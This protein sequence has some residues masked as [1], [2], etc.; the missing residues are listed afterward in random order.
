MIELQNAVGINDHNRIV[1]KMKSDMLKLI[2]SGT[3]K[4]YNDKASEILKSIG[5]VFKGFIC[6]KFMNEKYYV[7][8][9]KD[10]MVFYLIPKLIKGVKLKPMIK[11]SRENIILGREK[12]TKTMNKLITIFV[13]ENQ[14]SVCIIQT[15]NQDKREMFIT[16]SNDKIVCDVSTITNEYQKDIIEV[17]NCSS[18]I[19]YTLLKNVLY[20]IIK[21][22]EKYD[23]ST[24]KKRSD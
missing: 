23:K 22:R 7:N 4:K 15:E 12:E 20:C 21:I 19:R 3:I 5:K 24:G 8:V 17:I 14:I 6:E 2:K 9:D 1:K 18:N 11:I 13:S 10:K 16:I